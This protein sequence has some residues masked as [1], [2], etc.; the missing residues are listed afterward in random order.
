MLESLAGRVMAT[1]IH[2]AQMQIPFIKK[3]DRIFAE[4]IYKNKVNKLEETEKYEKSKLKEFL[5]FRRK[6]Y[7]NT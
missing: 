3:R 7:K 4:E 6:N 2:F 1:K 5:I